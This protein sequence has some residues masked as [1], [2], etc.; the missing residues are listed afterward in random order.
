[1]KEFRERFQGTPLK[2][3]RDLDG[4]PTTGGVLTKMLMQ[5]QLSGGALGV[6]TLDETLN[7]YLL[8]HGTSKD[9][10]DA[11]MDT[12]FRI[13]PIAHGARFGR[14]AYLAERIRKSL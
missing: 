1:M 14:G 13:G 9:A 3:A 11:I 8:F 12:G 4:D 10:C 2:H 5:T 7:E 6:D